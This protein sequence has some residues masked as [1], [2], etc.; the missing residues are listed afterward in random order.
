MCKK[1]E[2]FKKSWNFKYVM[3]ASPLLLLVNFFIA[4]KLLWFNQKGGSTLTTNILY[5]VVFAMLLGGYGMAF[6][7]DYAILDLFSTMT[8][9]ECPCVRSNREILKYMTYMKLLVNLLFFGSSL[10]SF[11]MLVYSILISLYQ[12]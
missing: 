9:K 11:D 10:L 12:V 6:A 1:L 7:N 2:G 5:Y 8:K 4:Y 3:I